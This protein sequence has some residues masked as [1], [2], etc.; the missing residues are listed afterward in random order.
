MST[1]DNSILISL[2]IKSVGGKAERE[3][4]TVFVSYPVNLYM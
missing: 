1:T 3:R 4:E 2:L